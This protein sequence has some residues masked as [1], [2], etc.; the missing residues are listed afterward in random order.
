MAKF[1]ANFGGKVS[2]VDYSQ[3]SLDITPD[4][5]YATERAKKRSATFVPRRLWYGLK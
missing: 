2:Q 4:S 3:S 1:Q 5:N